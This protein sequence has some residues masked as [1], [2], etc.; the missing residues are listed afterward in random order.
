M[1]GDWRG[2]QTRRR[3]V[4]HGPHPAHRH[5]PQRDAIYAGDSLGNEIDAI[6]SADA[7]SVTTHT[8][9]LEWK[10]R[11]RDRRSFVVGILIFQ[12]AV[13]V[14]AEFVV[15]AWLRRA[16]VLPVA[17]ADRLFAF[18]F[19]IAFCV[20]ILTAMVLYFAS[21]RYRDTLEQANAELSQ[22]V[23]RQVNAGLAR[24]NAMIFGLAKL[25]DY[26]DTDTGA[27]LERIGLY[28][29]VLADELRKTH[30]QI[31]QKWIDRIVLASSLHDI[32]KVGIPDSILLKP[33][34]LSDRERAQMQK[35]TLIGAD[36]L[37]AIRGQIGGDE[38]IDMGVE[39]A[40]QHHEK[41]DGTGYPFGLAGEGISLAARI[42]ALADFYDAVTSKRVYKDAMSHDEA[43]DLIRG[44]QGTHFDPQ[45]AD[46]FTANA[47]EFDAIRVQGQ[48]D[49]PGTL[50]IM[51]L[52]AV[53]RRFIDEQTTARFAD[54][55]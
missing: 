12:A 18:R 4:Y 29:R 33:G 53:A 45:V 27:H 30:E 10:F 52:E 6:G 34:A 55:A 43:C 24:R 7:R 51:D 41:W 20:F 19:S 25:A 14:A 49:D 1:G 32:G 50:R 36:T 44:L 13:L 31:D 17:S 40:L 42:V 16:F 54:A 35:H 48:R 46:A 37:L 15:D 47:D 39:I 5:S 8:K 26:R 3:S 23:A 11:P 38:F 22:E 21:R 9:K 28:V 2:P